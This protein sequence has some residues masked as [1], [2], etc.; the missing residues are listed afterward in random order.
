[1]SS[2]FSD[3]STKDLIG[4]KKY[5]EYILNK[6]KKATLKSWLL[7]LGSILFLAGIVGILERG[8]NFF[9]GALLVIGGRAAYEMY[10]EYKIYEDFKMRHDDVAEE[11]LRREEK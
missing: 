8:I 5:L 3:W 7:I 10:Q 11:L 4:H 2:E 1:M 9:N 6:S